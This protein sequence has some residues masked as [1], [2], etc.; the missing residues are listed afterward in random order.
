MAILVQFSFY[1][2]KIDILRNCKKLKRTKISI[3]ED[4]SQE[5]I[6]IRKGKWK[7]V[8][9]N[10]KEGKILYLQYRNVIYKEGVSHG[11]SM[12]SKNTTKNQQIYKFFLEQIY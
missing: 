12:L 8:L 9:S 4:F 11:S 1:K 7:K 2:D 3:F 10:R 6:Q 5:T